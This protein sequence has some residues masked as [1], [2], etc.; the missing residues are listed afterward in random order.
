[1]NES[2]HEYVIANLQARSIS[3]AEIAK[4]SGVSRRTIEK[5]ARREIADPSV[6]FV[7]K[8]A[9]YFRENPTSHAA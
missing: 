5:I 9:K 3:Y 1:M 2:M 7:E 8:L 4:G 6:S